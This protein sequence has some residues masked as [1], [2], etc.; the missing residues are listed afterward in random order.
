MRNA[1]G[2]QLRVIRQC[3]VQPVVAGRGLK[4]GRACPEL[5]RHRGRA[6]QPAVVQEGGRKPSGSVA[7]S[8]RRHR[9]RRPGR[10]QRPRGC[11]PR[12][13][14]QRTSRGSPFRRGCG[15]P[16]AGWDPGRRRRGTRSRVGRGR[17]GG[18]GRDG[19]CRARFVGSASGRAAALPPP[20][21]RR[22]ACWGGRC[23]PDW[24]AA[25]Q[26]LPHP[27]LCRRFCENKC[28]PSAIKAPGQPIVSC[29]S[30]GSK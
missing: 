2:P 30:T 12:A 15:R 17:A 26:L 4:L 23:I 10:G 11:G 27:C 13:S 1:Q 14:G 6:R 3:S 29:I 19:G 22:S 5:A 8:R 18:G 21:R 7:R 20:L 28:D 16:W 9:R 24:A 25:H